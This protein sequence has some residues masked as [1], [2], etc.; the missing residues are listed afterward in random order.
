MYRLFRENGIELEP[1][2]PYMHELNS[3]ATI[4][5]SARCLLAVS[6]VRSSLRQ[7]C[8]VATICL[9]LKECDVKLERQMEIDR[10]HTPPKPRDKM[11]LQGAAYVKY[12]STARVVAAIRV[13]GDASS[14]E[15]EEPERNKK[16]KKTKKEKVQ[17]DELW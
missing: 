3:T 1:C 4:M 16:S 12:Q 17:E 5:D 10:R 14:S 6:K 9:T 2:P 8:Q 11:K 15:E 7:G 13:E